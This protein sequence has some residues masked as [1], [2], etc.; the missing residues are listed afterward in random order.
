VGLNSIFRLPKNSYQSTDYGMNSY[1]L[2]KAYDG[3]DVY[4]TTTTTTTTTYYGMKDDDMKYNS[5]EPKHIENKN[6]YNPSDLDSN[7][8]SSF[9]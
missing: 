2:K 9:F 4:E 8:Q 7:N 3:Q 6:E 1:D 5:Y